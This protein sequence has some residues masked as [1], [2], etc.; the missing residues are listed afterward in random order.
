MSVPFRRSLRAD[1]ADGADRHRNVH[2]WQRRACE[3]VTWIGHH[4]LATRTPLPDLSLLLPPC[5]AVPIAGPETL[6][7]PET[8]KVRNSNPANGRQNTFTGVAFLTF[9]G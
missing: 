8:K 6:S 2:L 3:A 1:G 7:S 5:R 4:V 9:A